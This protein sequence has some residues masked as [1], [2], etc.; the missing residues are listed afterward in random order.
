M[1]RIA[2]QNH[3]DRNLT[4]HGGLDGT[5]H[6]TEATRPYQFLEF[7]SSDFLT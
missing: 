5:V 7:I 3:L 4:L 1:A 6:G 2:R